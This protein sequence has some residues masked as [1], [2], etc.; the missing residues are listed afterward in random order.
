[1]TQYQ[2][3]NAVKDRL[4]DF[5]AEVFFEERNEW[6][7]MT[8]SVYAIHSHF[9][10]PALWQQI[11]D[12]GN[13]EVTPPKTAEEI[14]ANKEGHNRTERGFILSVIVDP[15]VTN[16]LRWAPLSQEDKDSVATYRQALLDMPEQ[17]GW[18]VNAVWPDVPSI[19]QKTYEEEYG[20][21]GNPS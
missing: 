6:V 18:P 20:V 11:E 14:A 5:D 13:F 15:V 9:D 10:V 16:P 17:S 1:M 8:V 19:F 21:D 7:L 12:S 3:R 2:F 4:G